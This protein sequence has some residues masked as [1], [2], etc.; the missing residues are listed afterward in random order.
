[1]AE[2]TP[3]TDAFADAMTPEFRNQYE[4]EAWAILVESIRESVGPLTR[5]DGLQLERYCRYLIRWR[6]IEDKLEKLGNVNISML[7]DKDQQQ[8][9]RILWSES[10]AMDIALKQ[11]ED[12]FGMTP[13]SRQKLDA[14]SP[15]NEAG[16]SDSSQVRTI[17][18]NHT[19]TLD[20]IN[21]ENFEEHK[22]AFAKRL[23]ARVAGFGEDS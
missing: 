20:V 22:Q 5:L 6:M 15:A 2:P 4:R 18:H 10:R 8:T 7:L 23:V 1:M 11:I 21:Y 9:L 14:G 16:G 13:M 3:I 12:K 19:H 17:H